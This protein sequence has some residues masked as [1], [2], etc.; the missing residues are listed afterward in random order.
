MI[1]TK[2]I[3]DAISLSTVMTITKRHRNE[4]G[5]CRDC[6][7]AWPCDVRILEGLLIEEAE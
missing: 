5:K 1:T 3:K 4:E 6:G 2:Q 7:E